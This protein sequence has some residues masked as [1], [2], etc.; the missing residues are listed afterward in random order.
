MTKIPVI[1]ASIKIYSSYKG[2]IKWN[3]E[4][5]GKLNGNE[6]IRDIG[7]FELSRFHCSSNVL[8]ASD[9]HQSSLQGQEE[10]NRI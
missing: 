4:S 8:K 10:N 3:K 9:H 5:I 6:K 1:K 2:K 7:E